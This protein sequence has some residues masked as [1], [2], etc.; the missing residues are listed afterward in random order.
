M[1]GLMGSACA[2]QVPGD[3]VPGQI[4]PFYTMV[5][6][7]GFSAGPAPAGAVCQAWSAHIQAAQPTDYYGNSLSWSPSVNGSTCVVSSAAE[8]VSAPMSYVGDQLSCTTPDSSPGQGGASGTCYCNTG[9][10]LISNACVPGVN[11]TPAT[12]KTDQQCQSQLGQVV[13]GTGGST[14]YD[15]PAG[16]HTLC[17]G[18]CVVQPTYVNGSGAD[19]YAVGPMVTIGGSCDGVG[20]GGNGQP[21]PSG[22]PTPGAATADPAATSCAPQC[23]GQ[24]NGQTIC[25]PCGTSTQNGVSTSSSSSGEPGAA[26]TPGDVTT[27]SQTD[28]GDGTTTKSTTTTHPDGSSDTKIVIG[29]TK[30][31][32]TTGSS[33]AASGAGQ[34][35]GLCDQYPAL[36]ICKTSTFAGSCG[37][38]F[39]C[40]GDAIQCA[41][42]Q[43]Q[44]ARACQ[45]FDPASQGGQVAT[46]AQTLATARTD[47]DVP[48]WSPAHPS[49]AVVTQG[50]FATQIDQTNPY[51]GTCPADKVISLDSG[52]SVTIPLSNWCGPMQMLGRL[53]VAVSLLAA[54]FI[55]FKG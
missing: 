10:T 38:T 35:T 42:A 51:G 28:N 2:D 6:G 32:G 34:G 16:Q 13:P 23:P 3:V 8:T 40:S 11:H 44:H 26:P 55:V 1:L 46:D 49:N 37:G 33:S 25:V 41:I 36:S 53:V 43:E 30:A 27:T 7:D 12:P 39:A 54:A 24:V 18:G 47:G 22:K 21:P 29:P 52:S 50:D 20:N 5:R 15:M 14:R 45:F 17:Y 4:L 9:K 48:S 31:G 19:T